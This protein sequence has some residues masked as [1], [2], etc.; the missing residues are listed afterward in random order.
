MLNSFLNRWQALSG[1][2][3]GVWLVMLAMLCW[4]GMSAV[5]KQLGGS[6]LSAEQLV[7]LRA[8]VVLVMLLPLVLRS[9]GRLVLTRNPKLHLIRGFFI[10]SSAFCAAWAV[11]RLPL[12]ETNAYLM[13][14]SLFMLPLGVLFLGERAHWLRWAGVGVGFVG[15]LVMVR[16]G[17][18][19]FQPAVLVA[20][21][22][23][24]FEAG[25]GVALKKLG[26]VEPITTII[27]W[28][29][30][31]NW[32]VFGLLSGFAL[33]ALPVV[34]WWLLPVLGLCT[35]GVFVCYIHAYRLGDASA[36]E[37]GSF[38]L[39]LFSPLLGYFCFGE[40]PQQAF[41]LGAGLLVAGIALVI[42]E[43]KGRAA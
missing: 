22:C 33:P 24:L 32:L 40:V 29:Y 36:V 16:P 14:V 10:A 15:V 37:A 4:A 25:L 27:W 8:N 41:W 12:A 9:R 5:N 35:L 3:R 34:A 20:L 11:T 13:T 23:A 7:F 43:P 28:S 42:I 1:N 26:S 6:G 2:T 19:A 38:S 31:T 39:L 17:A 18:D 30:L 21:M